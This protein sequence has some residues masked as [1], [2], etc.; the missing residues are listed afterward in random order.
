M[1]PLRPSVRLVTWKHHGDRAPWLVQGFKEHGKPVRLFF[2]TRAA[3]EAEIVR[4]RQALLK[5]GTAADSFT[6]QDRLDLAKAKEILAPY[7]KTVVEAATL[8]ATYLQRAEKSCT[9]DELR[10]EILKAKAQDGKKVRYLQDLRSRLGRFCEDFGEIKVAVVTGPEIDDWLRA[11]P[12]SPVSRNNFRTVLNALFNFAVARRYRADNPIA[13]I[14][15]AK[16]ETGEPEIFT[17]TEMRALLAAA[18]PE[19][20]PALAIGAFAGLR[21][22]E[23]D[24]LEWSEIDLACGFIEVK[25]ENAKNSQKRF[26]TIL[27]N[28]AAWL[29]PYAGHA[30]RVRAPREKDL[31]LAARKA[32]KFKSWPD[33]GLRHSFASY[34]VAHFQDSAAVAAQ[35]GHPD[36]TMLF[37]HYRNVVRPDA[38][39]LWWEIAPPPSSSPPICEAAAT[40]PS[41]KTRK[42]P[43]AR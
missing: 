23:I 37:N 36:A 38:A 29:T 33:N 34:H 3:A 10:E 9:V 28:L 20:R 40:L 17:V 31:L 39:A 35:L 42:P 1:K 18:A 43:A 19:I 26:V 21:R 22:A 12:L 13:E 30:G 24:R 16:V 15:K 11:L 2:P 5:Y 4:R 14:V 8:T 41:T 6:A 27:P 25:S 32:A 7:G